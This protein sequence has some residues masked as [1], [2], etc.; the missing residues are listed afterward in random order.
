MG[1]LNIKK[2]TLSTDKEK[3]GVKLRAEPDHK[4]LGARL[5]GAFKDVTK[6][7]KALSDAQVSA[8]IRDEKMTVLGH[9]LGPEDLRVMYSFDG[10]N[11]KYEAHSEGDI[12]VL[13]DCTPDQSML[14]EGVAREVVNRVQRLRKKAK[15]QP[16]DLVTVQYSVEPSTHDLVRVIKEHRDYIESSTK[17]SMTLDSVSGAMLISEDYEL[18]GAKMSL[19][20]W[21]EE[22]SDQALESYGTPQVPFLNVVCGSESG[23][24]LLENP[25]GANKL[26]S[27]QNVAEE[28]G[29]LFGLQEVSNL[30][31]K[32]GS[33]VS[34]NVAD[35]NGETIYVTKVSNG[36]GGSCCCPFVNVNFGQQKGC[37]LLR[38][39]HSSSTDHSLVLPSIFGKPVDK[40]NLNDCQN[41]QTLTLS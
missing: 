1:E 12:L 11:D 17:N 21:K 36:K 16:S 5:K 19:K 14:D 7:I 9:E 38:N 3:Y 24:V 2:L 31:T 34:G 28:V 4:T 10:D 41:G 35:L 33:K 32:C 20:I 15:L 18:K 8:F 13:L 25:L 27:W 29:A 22:K 30:Y 39:P 6:E 40:I 26:T 23:V 37:L